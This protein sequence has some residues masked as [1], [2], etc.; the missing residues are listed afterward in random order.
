MKLSRKQW[1]KVT[2]TDPTIARLQSRVS[3]VVPGLLLFSFLFGVINIILGLL[4]GSIPVSGIIFLAAI[5]AFLLAVW[6]YR[7]ELSTIASIIFTTTLITL[8]LTMVYTSAPVYI[9]ILVLFIITATSTYMF[10]LLPAIL[11]TLLTE[12]LNL[13][14]NW[15]AS[16]LNFPPLAMQPTLDQVVLQTVSLLLSSI[17][18]NLFLE[19]PARILEPVLKE[20]VEVYPPIEPD[21]ETRLTEEAITPAKHHTP[22][23]IARLATQISAPEELMS[24]ACDL[25]REIGDYYQV[26]IYL[27]DESETW[28]E[29]AAGTGTIGQSLLARQHRLAVGSAS[30][31]GWVTANRLSRIA[32]DVVRDPFYFKHP[33]LPD[34]RSEM[35]FPLLIGNRLIGVLDVQ[36]TEP[37][38]F[39]GENLRILEAA[40]N[41]L[42]IAIE[43]VRLLSE[44]RFRLERIEREYTE[45]SMESWQRIMRG[46]PKMEY[47][48]G[49]S[50]NSD[51]QELE[52]LIDKAA[53]I[54]QTYIDKERRALAVPIHVRGQTIAT[55]AVRKQDNQEPWTD[56]D[57]ALIE[58]LSSQTSLAL[59]TARQYSEE[60]RRVAELEVINR[61]SQA[62]SQLL[63]LDSLY[64]VVHAQLKQVLGNTDLTIALYDSDQE[65]ISF[66]YVTQNQQGFEIPAMD[67]GENAFGAVLRNRQPVL[68]LTSGEINISFGESTKTLPKAQ[69]W[70]GVPMLFGNEVVGFI[71]LHDPYQEQ[72]FTED[73]TALLSTIS[74]QIATAIQNTHLLKQIRNSA[75]RDQ[76]IREITTHIRRAPDIQSILDTSVKELGRAL[77]AP[78][79][80]VQL[81]TPRQEQQGENAAAI[82]ADESEEG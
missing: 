34:T 50:P 72:R 20:P 70:M 6:L 78:L 44:T 33:L 18:I 9:T 77:N 75:H 51:P 47:R 80:R 14:S 49:M 41:E 59:E 63:R 28:A 52:N 60:Q 25:I 30:L 71:A 37:R 12:A 4:E 1:I 8:F 66:P 11:I 53:S 76:L 62:V 26:S 48:K 21:A 64:R 56:D 79:T 29:I 58:T 22:G 67:I 74:S 35:V 24:T 61:I 3:T 39:T 43:N 7:I 5:P 73:D 2:S 82:P 45:Q 15:F 81:S 17:L 19:N 65:R 69:S 10:G 16:G 40:G 27:I 42:A 55:I 68:L 57:I 54:R 38:T 31:I 13:T 32:Q 23:E 36:S 46:K